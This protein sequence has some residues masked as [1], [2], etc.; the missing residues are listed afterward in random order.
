VPSSALTAAWVPLPLG[1]VYATGIL[2]IGCGIAMLVGRYASSAAAVCGSLMVALTLAL[3]VPQFFLAR[4][5]SQQVTA[6]NFVFDTL[7]FAGMMF[8]T[9]GAIA[10][11]ESQVIA[12]SREASV[13][14]T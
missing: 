10:N 1:V 12:R 2:L 5:T 6:I 14:A 4:N 3:Y 11:T 7:L 9:S 8:A 13:F